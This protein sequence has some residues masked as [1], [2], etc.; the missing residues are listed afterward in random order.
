ML[1][2][3]E[4]CAALAPLEATGGAVLRLGSASE[5]EILQAVKEKV[6]PTVQVQPAQKNLRMTHVILEGRHIILLVNEGREPAASTLAM[7]L[8]GLPEYWDA[9]KG[10]CQK[11]PFLR[12]GKKLLVP[13]L[14]EGLSS[15]AVVITPAC[16]LVIPQPAAPT[17]INGVLS[18]E[19]SFDWAGDTGQAHLELGEVGAL[20]E[21]T[22]NKVFAGALMWEPFGIDIPVKPGMNQLNILVRESMANRYG[23]PLPSGLLRDIIITE[24]H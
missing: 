6:F 10:S 17:A 19:L 15:L 12:D 18:Y 2:D 14:L 3:P 22:V 16:R 21:V 24:I 20:A 5:K 9:W 4:V 23:T 1:L 11:A 8:E 13:V 7:N